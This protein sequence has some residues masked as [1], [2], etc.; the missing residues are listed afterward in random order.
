MAKDE[1]E[2]LT[3]I[4]KGVKSALDEE[5]AGRKKLEAE[6]LEMKKLLNPDTVAESDSGATAP[7]SSPDMKEALDY[8]RGQKAVEEER[9]K[10]K[11]DRFKLSTPEQAE[12]EADELWQNILQNADV[13]ED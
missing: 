5:R 12:K 1:R 4:L 7:P 10:R 3:E 11:K 8:I 6:V 13:E 9:Q 2:E